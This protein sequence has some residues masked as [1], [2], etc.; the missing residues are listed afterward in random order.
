MKYQAVVIGASAGGLNAFSEVL[1]ELSKDFSLPIFIVQ[2]LM[3]NDDSY[4][5]T[6]LNQI[7]Q[8]RT[9]I[10]A[11][12]KEIIQKNTIYVAPPGYHMLIENKAAIAL[13]LEPPVNYSRPSIDLLFSSACDVYKNQLIAILLTGANQDGSIG[14]KLINQT[15]GMCIVQDPKSA[16]APMMPES[17]I[18][19]VPR[20]KVMQLVEIT[21]WL[22]QMEMKNG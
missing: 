3:E 21:Q 19:K 6:H 4:L 1:T 10:E 22:N 11:C 5:A 15:G 16:S 12:D 7:T 14:L 17:A 18:I 13:S 9:V 20:A 8:G 2:H